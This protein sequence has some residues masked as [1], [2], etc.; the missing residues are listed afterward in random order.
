MP[1]VAMER[2]PL[3]ARLGG[4]LPPYQDRSG[5]TRPLNA[6]AKG[7]PQDLNLTNRFFELQEIIVFKSFDVDLFP[8]FEA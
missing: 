5:P 8:M 4:T 6:E 3:C 2:Q 1:A 7:G